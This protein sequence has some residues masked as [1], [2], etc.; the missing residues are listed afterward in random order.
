M[1]VDPQ[2]VTT[3]PVARTPDIVDFA[4]SVARAVDVIQTALRPCNRVATVAVVAYCYGVA[5]SVQS[6]TTELQLAVGAVIASG[7]DEDADTRAVALQ[8]IKGRGVWPSHS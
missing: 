4:V 3:V 7:L 5:S 2:R 6:S 1:G 8:P